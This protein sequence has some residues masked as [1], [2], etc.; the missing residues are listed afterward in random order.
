MLCCVSA[1]ISALVCQFFDPRETAAESV[2][3]IR[4]QSSLKSRVSRW[5]FADWGK[6]EPGAKVIEGER[7][8]VYGI[9]MVIILESA[10]EV[11]QKDA[12]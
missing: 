7:R 1:G 4:R 9:K 5:A 11:L 2:Q 6:S 12:Q 8:C 3:A 10:I